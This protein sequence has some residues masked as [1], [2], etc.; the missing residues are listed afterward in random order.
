MKL[1]YVTVVLS[2]MCLAQ[3]ATPQQS[4]TGP[5]GQRVTFSAGTEL[6]AQ[7]DKTVDAKKAKAGDPVQA[8]TLDELMSGTQ[9]LAPRG[10]R[11]S[12]HVVAASPHEKDSASRLEIAF[13]KLDLGNGT[14]VPLNATIQALAGPVNNT[15]P[16]A[17]NTTG[18]PTGE[19][20]STGMGGRGTMQS[21]GMGQPAG[22]PN[23]G[24][25]GNSG[26]TAGSNPPSSAIAANA[27]GV[28]GI[29]GVSLSPGPSRDSVLT[30]EKHNVK[31]ESGTQMIL[32]TQ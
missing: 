24:N 22:A 21:G 2:A 16:A 9:V 19:S 20:P 15:A 3:N 8:K 5:S 23:T 27:Q 14:E 25:M 6:R 12:G 28:Q 7:L 11:I 10:A 18:S 13:D 1:F 17:D 31:L 4:G 26:T 32:R 30:S 29:S